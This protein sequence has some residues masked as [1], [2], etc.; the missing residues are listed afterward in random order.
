MAYLFGDVMR[1]RQG[2]LCIYFDVHGNMERVSHPTGADIVNSLDS[3]HFAGNSQDRGYNV[4]IASL[5]SPTEGEDEQCMLLHDGRRDT[6]K[7]LV[8][9]PL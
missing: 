2:E 8:S 6:R 1:L 4:R 5:S 9:R 3:W 7:A